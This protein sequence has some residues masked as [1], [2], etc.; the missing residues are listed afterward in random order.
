[1]M[2]AVIDAIPFDRNDRI[3]MLDLGCG[4]ENLGRKLFSAYLNAR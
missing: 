2:Q 1:M 4:T 3:K